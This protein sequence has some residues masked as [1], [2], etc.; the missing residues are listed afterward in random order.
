MPFHD[1]Y[2]RLTPYELAFPD[3]G[4]AEER[5]G[6]IR[7]DARERGQEDSVADPGRFLALPGVAEVL[8]Q[9]RDPRSDADAVQKHGI[10]LYH[11]FHFEEADRSLFLLDTHAARYLVESAPFGAEDE[12]EAP[13][14]P[15]PSGYVQLPRNLFW[16]RPSE[17]GPPE[18]VDG[19]FWSAPAGGRIAVVVTAGIRDDRP[20]FSVVPLPAVPLEEAGT[21]LDV[22]IRPT[23]RDFES[24][25]PGGEMERLYSL[26]AAG[27]AL[28]LLARLFR[29][30]EL[31]PG[32]VR[33]E[34]P[35]RPGAREKPEEPESPEEPPDRRQTGDR[36]PQDEA[37]AGG[38]R[39]PA[40]GPRPSALP[41]RRITLEDEP[42]S[43]SENPAAP[44]IE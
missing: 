25:L 33:E 9:I 36:A 31:F 37:P 14:P 22:E 3:R 7:E 24:T 17:D 16:I 10:L 21:W 43:T 20:G 32:A 35:E 13:G 23:E 18:P 12:D 1:A 28:K 2:A 40:E 6:R 26:E 41:Y 11:L 29:Y 39:E 42:P 19:L 27:E 4:F 15:E 38:T 34:A 44:S 5:L 30:L 8:Q